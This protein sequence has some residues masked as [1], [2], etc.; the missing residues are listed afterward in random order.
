MFSFKAFSALVAASLLASSVGAS[1]APVRRQSGCLSECPLIVETM[2][3]TTTPPTIVDEWT[4]NL[5]TSSFTSTTLTCSYVQLIPV[6]LPPVPTGTC[7][8]DVATGALTGGT[9]SDCPT[10][11]PATVC[12]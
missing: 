9:I 5:L 7:V 1:V 4:L 2:D 10:S 11:V 6:S 8:Y 3:L 12:A